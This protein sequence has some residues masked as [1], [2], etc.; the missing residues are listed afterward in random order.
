MSGSPKRIVVIGGGLSGLAAA[1]RL[2]ELTR[3][4]QQ[5][6]EVTL[7]E[8]S[9]HVGGVVGTAH[10]D[11]YMVEQGADSFIT[12]K[13]W[14][15]RL[16]ER[17]GLEDQLVAMDTEFAGLYVLR[18]GEPMSVPA[19]FTLLSPGKL[20]PMLKSPL[21][22]ARGKFR[23]MLEPLMKA[24]K[25]ATDESLASFARRRIGSEIFDRLVQPLIGGIY[26][27]DPEKLSMQATM[28]R[29]IEMEQK[30]GSL[31][32]GVRREGGQS[33]GA[34][35]SNVGVRYGLFASLKD[36]MSKLVETLA[37]RVAEGADVRTGQRVLAVTPV[38]AAGN[39]T[40]DVPGAWQVEL[41][42][43]EIIEADAVIAS[44]AAYRAADFLETTDAALAESLRSIEYASSAIV[45]SGHALSDIR[46]PLD[47]YGLVVPHQENR[48]VLA[49]SFTSRKYS[50]RAPE[51]KV[52]L[53][54][55]VGGALQPELMNHSDT[56]IEEIVNRE[57]SEIL[58]VQKPAEW[59]RTFRYTRAM[60]QYH[61]GH[62]QRVDAIDDLVAQYRGLALSGNAYRGVGV[63][64]VIHSGECAAE[65][66]L[67]EIGG[68]E[69]VEAVHN[70]AV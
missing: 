68:S 62:L 36:G 47:A 39:A 35:Q 2:L 44:C 53:R 67:Q 5:S 29:F 14:A 58:G 37:G 57:L 61:V 60:P 21:F 26:T 7:L 59:M 42:D 12:N 34:S 66:I 9:P 40:D 1:H 38:Q 27:S 51:G 24:R 31:A 4:P 16:C 54:T 50:G 52:I 19:G 11:G 17:L 63:P 15:I 56:A 33:K 49:I 25:E 46:H 23:M 65:R 43:G 3:Q 20:W 10:I 28:A 48:D 6:V 32:R 18:N 45:A 69:V 13:P 55:F 70:G 41:E 64:D 30:W 8:A 22:S